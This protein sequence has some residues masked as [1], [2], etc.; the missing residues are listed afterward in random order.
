MNSDSKQ[1]LVVKAVE[2]AADREAFIRLPW[3][4]YR[5]DPAWVP[6][7]L[8]ER[9]DH[10]NPRKNPFFDRA[11][12]RFWLALRGGRAVGRISAQVNQAHLARHH[13]ATGHFGM[14]EAEDRTETFRTLLTTA[15][16]WLR[17]H[18]MQQ[19][20]GPFSLSINEES[21]LLVDG[22]EYPPSLMMGH[23]RPYYAAQLEALGYRKN[24]DLLC[25]H[26]DAKNEQPAAVAVLLRKA[27]TTEKLTVRSLDMRRYA[28]DL[29][30]IMEVFN[31][32]W[33]ENWGFVPMSQAEI[34]RLAKDLKP[35]IRPQSIA[36]AELNGAPVAMAIGVPNVNEAITDLDGRLLP[37]GWAKLLWRLKV[38]TTKTVRV[39]LMGVRREYH[40]SMLGATLAFAVIDRI[41]QAQ[42]SLG[43]ESAELSWILE[44]NQPMRRLIEHLGGVVYK[45]YRLYQRELS[46]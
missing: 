2:S 40:G 46:P 22:F 31:D 3:T 12:A 16:T 39:P 38:K 30:N 13:D 6:P 27:D 33:A 5:D 25:Y 20:V 8:Q 10:L 28:Q 19:A 34:H 24:K 44:D 7:L 35:I 17:G 14:L 26:Y 9:R 15:E 21:G 43:V 36:I 4:L 1:P 37:F 18:G 42:R 41:L 45:T 11:E 23:A 29:N 32:A